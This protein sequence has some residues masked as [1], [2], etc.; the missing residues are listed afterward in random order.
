MESLT[1]P[2]K[3]SGVGAI[4]SSSVATGAPAPFSPPVATLSGGAE[5]DIAPTPPKARPS[6]SA[7]HRADSSPG[8]KKVAKGEAK[9]PSPPKCFPATRTGQQAKNA[10]RKL[11]STKEAR[12][13][14]PKPEARHLKPETRSPKPRTRKLKPKTPN[15][16]PEARNLN[17]ETR[18]QKPRTRNPTPNTRNPKTETLTPALSTYTLNPKP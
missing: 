15:P 17:P 2:G 16:K 11:A 10:A 7:R 9:G 4:S 6:P 12:A 1:I 3:A 5:E 13:R 8:Q 14:N 18:S